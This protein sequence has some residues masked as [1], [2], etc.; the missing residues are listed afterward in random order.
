MEKSLDGMDSNS[1]HSHMSN[2]G[3][4][5]GEPDIVSMEAAPTQEKMSLGKVKFGSAD[6][7]LALAA[8]SFAGTRTAKIIHQFKEWDS[9]HSVDRSIAKT[10]STDNLLESRP[11]ATL[12]KYYDN[13]ANDKAKVGRRS[14]IED[15]PVDI[16]TEG[17]GDGDDDKIKKLKGFPLLLESIFHIEERGRVLKYLPTLFN[18]ALCLIMLLTEFRNSITS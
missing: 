1:V 11:N 14:V 7:L 8:Q 12:Q 18:N 15:N 17:G 16:E 3:S 2:V 10:N 6:D 13:Y 5:S 9:T 4:Q